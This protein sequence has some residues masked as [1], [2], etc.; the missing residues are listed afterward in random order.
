M[1]MLLLAVQ[2]AVTPTALGKPWPM[3]PREPLNR[4]MDLP[5]AEGPFARRRSKPTR[6]MLAWKPDEGGRSSPQR[7]N[8]WQFTPN[9]APKKIG[10]FLNRLP[11]V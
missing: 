5:E 4:S 1:S 11:E 7:G 8:N 9:L 3:P 6:L 10:V 2:K